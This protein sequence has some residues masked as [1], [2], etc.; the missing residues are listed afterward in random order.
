MENNKDNTVVIAAA[1]AALVTLVVLKVK[2][3]TVRKSVEYRNLKA[4]KDIKKAQRKLDRMVL[5]FNKN[6]NK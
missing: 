1:T 3:R 5:E 2:T 4:M 6:A